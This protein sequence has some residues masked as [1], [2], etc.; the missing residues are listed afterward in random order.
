MSHISLHPLGT[1][2]VR[3]GL[4]AVDRSFPE[5]LR[6]GVAEHDLPEEAIW[7]AW[8]LTRLSPSLT[9]AAA[10]RQRLG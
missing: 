5:E 10:R 3:A 6:A 8:E 7:I 2:R 9:L 4:G 1:A